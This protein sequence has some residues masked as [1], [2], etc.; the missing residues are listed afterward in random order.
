MRLVQRHTDRQVL[1]TVS[2]PTAGSSNP[3]GASTNPQGPAV[4]QEGRQDSSAPT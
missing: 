3:D 4:N 2:E 1:Q